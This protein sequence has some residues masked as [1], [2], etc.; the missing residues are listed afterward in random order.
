MYFYYRRKQESRNFN[1]VAK[2]ITWPNEL[3]MKITKFT[4]QNKNKEKV[5]HL[6]T[7]WTLWE[8]WARNIKN[9]IMASEKAI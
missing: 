3:S 1:H 7:L 4:K 5:S 8:D 6:P 2:W 9:P